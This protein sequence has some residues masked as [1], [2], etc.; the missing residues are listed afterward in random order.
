MADL[1]SIESGV[2]SGCGRPSSAKRLRRQTASLVASE[3]ASISASQEERATVGC[4]LDDQDIAAEPC[5]KTHPE[6]K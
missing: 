4:F 1:L 3:A 5:V 6:V 2:G